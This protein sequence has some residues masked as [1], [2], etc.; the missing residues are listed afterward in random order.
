MKTIGFI[1]GMSWESSAIYYQIANREVNARLGKSH[2]S[3]NIMVSVDFEE[4]ATLQH[5]GAWQKLTQIMVE[6]A[7]SLERAGAHFVVICTNTMHL[8]APE[9][10]AAVNIPL[11]HIADAVGESIKQQG[12]KKVGLLGTRYTM[13]KG[14]YKDHLAKN[15][16]IEVITP[17]DVDRADVHNIIYN[18]LVLG[19]F[20][21]A[22]REVYQEVVRHLQTN[23][24]EGV[25]LGCTEIPL[26][27]QQQHVGIP[28]FDTTTI[29]AKKA[30]E[31]S[32]AV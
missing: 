32:L 27:I 28:L 8:M 6:A 19:K 26:L 4:I 31:W 11:L 18:E 15:Y 16:G 3:R 9:V 30:V 24:A 14:F 5:A 10:Q 2:S 29:H 13:E 17:N 25:I 1:G 12:I 20:W 21:D 7:L 22:S 23:G